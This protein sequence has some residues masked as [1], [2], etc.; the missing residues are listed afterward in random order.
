V[1]TNR[2]KGIITLLLALAFLLCAADPLRAQQREGGPRAGG[3]TPFLEPIVPME[4]DSGPFDLAAERLPRAYGGHNIQRVYQS[5]MDSMAKTA[6]EQG[7]GRE[8]RT[9]P[10]ERTQEA[11]GVYAFPVR[12]AEVTY[13]KH[14]G[15][16]EISCQLW[17][18]LAGGAAD[19]AKSGFRVAYIPRVDHTYTYAGPDG[20]NVEVEE[21]KF[22]EYT[23]AFAN[24]DAFPLDLR[25]EKTKGAP[26]RDPDESLRSGT[27]KAGTPAEKKEIGELERNLRL[28]VVCRLTGPYATS[29][30]QEVKGT[31]ESPGEYLA[32]HK[33][34]HV[35]I[36]GLWLYDAYTGKIFEKIGPS[37]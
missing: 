2:A 22:R 9:D 7:N 37:R 36:L 23:I 5:V 19:Q 17:S 25:P 34:L 4:Y 18:V 14:G 12:P 29:E 16:M 1:K 8:R 32:E 13:D 28:L 26:I 27:I 35:R 10:L 3:P 21:V 30:T 15:K 11:N 33:Y 24:L 20:K 31:P 6:R